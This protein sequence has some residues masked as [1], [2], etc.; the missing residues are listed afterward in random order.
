MMGKF[1]KNSIEKASYA[2]IIHLNLLIWVHVIF[3][4]LEYW[5][6]NE[7]SRFSHSSRDSPLFDGN[8]EW[9]HCRRRPICVPWVADPPIASHGERQRVLFWIKQKERKFTHST[10]SR[11]LLGKTFWTPCTSLESVLIVHLSQKTTEFFKSRDDSEAI[12]LGLFIL[13]IFYWVI[14]NSLRGTEL[15]RQIQTDSTATRQS[16]YPYTRWFTCAMPGDHLPT[17]SRTPLLCPRSPNWSTQWCRI[18]SQLTNQRIEISWYHSTNDWFRMMWNPRGAMSVSQ[19]PES[20]SKFE[21]LSKFLNFCGIPAL[22]KSSGI[23]KI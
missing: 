23:S 2:V 22:S 4:S 13:T 1:K 8:L 19:L 9:P 21:F 15:A 7:G 14:W 3:G 11:H 10:F 18:R 20:F 16:L 17:R 6:K 12:R 5:K